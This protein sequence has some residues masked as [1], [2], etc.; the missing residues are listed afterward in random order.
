M[1]TFADQCLALP[2]KRHF[3]Q[4]RYE[5]SLDICKVFKG[6]ATELLPLERKWL[7]LL[8]TD[9]CGNDILE[10]SDYDKIKNE[11]NHKASRR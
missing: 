11:S 6:A 7:V 3:W 5:E 9:S 2:L 10:C 8:D 1:V 4:D